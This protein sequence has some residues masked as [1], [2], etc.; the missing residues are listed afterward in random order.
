MASVARA[1]V[2]LV[3]CA[4]VVRGTEAATIDLDASVGVGRSDNIA[5]TSNGER[6]AT[7]GSAGF[8]FS[9]LE[10]TRRIDVDLIGDLSWLDYAGD[11]Y[12]SEVVG[13]ATGRIRLDLAR[14]RLHWVVEDRFG[15]TRRDLFSVP[16]PLNREN[17][18]YFSTGPDVRL[19]LG[20]PVNL[21][22]GGRYSLVD[23][24]ESLADSSRLSGW[25]GVEYMLSSTARAS[26]NASTERIEPRGSS[27]ASPYDRR[28]GYL[29]YALA[30]RRTS[31][32][33][34]AGVNRVQGGDATHS[35]LLLRVELGRDLGRLSR[36]TVRLGH[37][38]TDPGA[39]LGLA[40]DGQLS[41]PDLGD[42]NLV[43][44]SQP[45]DN[46]YVDAQWRIAGR[47]TAIDVLAGFSAE[48][49]RGETTLDLRRV[50]LGA[51]VSR[52]LRARTSATAGVRYNRN[53]YR[54]GA[55]DNED[56]TYTAA[57]SWS[58]GRALGFELAGEYFGYSPEISSGAHEIRYWL[59]TRYGKRVSR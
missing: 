14:D 21:L 5:R 18:N 17:V 46:R 39:T 45:F 58:V 53:D 40:P 1:V 32:A 52:T 50:S 35:D 9:V 37:E 23:Y 8:Q 27:I 51:S 28:A 34:D 22:L 49:Y 24:E 42:A 47:R 44:S 4:A 43:Q 36:L 15:Q 48:D 29:R 19:A 16:N 33:L 3:C 6:S 26:V 31:L 56:V 2:M 12:A 38:I 13:A 10:Q 54:S 25:G 20:A 59:R 7:I 41:M 57:L 55:G 11:T 30:G